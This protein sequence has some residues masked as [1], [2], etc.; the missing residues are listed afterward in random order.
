M[1]IRQQR[2]I[3]ISKTCCS[4]F[5]K[6]KDEVPTIV[7]LIEILGR[8][9]EITIKREKVSKYLGTYLDELL[10]WEHQIS[11]PEDGLLAK[12]T[13]TNNSFKIVN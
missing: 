7:N 2:T 6:V 3:N 9:H 12:L 11:H 4:I 13:K 1:V 10:N 5:H 8:E